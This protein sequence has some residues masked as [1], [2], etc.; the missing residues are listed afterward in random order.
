M[1]P[2]A[3]STNKHSTLR[4]IF[5]VFQARKSFSTRAAVGETSGSDEECK[6]IFA[7]VRTMLINTAGVC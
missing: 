5:S 7:W 4:L 3:A 2:L 6:I 1:D